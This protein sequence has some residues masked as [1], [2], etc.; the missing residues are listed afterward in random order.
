[1]P[2]QLIGINQDKYHP[3]SEKSCALYNAEYSTK[4]PSSG[5]IWT[6]ALL[7]SFIQWNTE[8]GEKEQDHQGWRNSRTNIL[9]N[10]LPQDF[11]WF[12]WWFMVLGTYIQVCITGIVALPLPVIGS[13]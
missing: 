2:L 9:H 6:A 11:K 4:I 3:A 7:P 13:F 12:K 10:M 8:K 1:M 5:R